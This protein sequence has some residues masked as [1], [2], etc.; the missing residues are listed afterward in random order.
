MISCTEWA[1][2]FFSFF[3]W[4]KNELQVALLERKRLNRELLS[5]ILKA[6]QYEKVKDG[7][8]HVLAELI[9]SM[10]A[11]YMALLRTCAWRALLCILSAVLILLCPCLVNISTLFVLTRFISM[12]PAGVLYAFIIMVWNWPPWCD[13]HIHKQIVWR[14]SSDTR[15][16]VSMWVVNLLRSGYRSNTGPLRVAVHGTHCVNSVNFTGAFCQGDGP[17]FGSLSPNNP[18]TAPLL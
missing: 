15:I 9:R 2:S 3:S 8:H 12:K 14:K 10:A 4:Q 17:W 6:V 11:H 16:G 13:K 5:H 1:D 18:Q 7:Q